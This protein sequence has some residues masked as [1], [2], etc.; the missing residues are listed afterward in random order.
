MFGF[1]RCLILPHDV[2]RKRVKKLENGEYIGVCR[3]CHAKLKRV[4]RD[5]WVRDWRA[6]PK[7]EN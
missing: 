4:K 1:I 6:R 7:P 5:R 3:H 2:H